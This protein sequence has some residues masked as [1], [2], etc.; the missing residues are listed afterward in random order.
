MISYNWDSKPRMLKLKQE[1][2][3]RGLTVWIDVERMG[4][5]H[6]N[7]W[8]KCFQHHRFVSGNSGNSTEMYYTMMKCR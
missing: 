5:Y 8:M 4:K 2:T 1:L 3:Q 6:Q 7:E